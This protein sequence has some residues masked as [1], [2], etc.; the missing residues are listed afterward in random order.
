MQPCLKGGHM[1]DLTNRS[2]ATRKKF[3]DIGKQRRVKKEWD[4]HREIQA[5]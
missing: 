3:T 1:E 2:H 5:S 4:V